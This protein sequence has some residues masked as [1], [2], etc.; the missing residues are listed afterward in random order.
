MKVSA[1]ADY[2]VRAAIEIAAS[3]HVPVKAERI[4]DRQAIPLTFLHKILHELRMAG[5]IRTSRGPEGGHEL[6]RPPSEISIADVL[7]AVEGPL[8]AVRNAAPESVQYVGSAAPLQNVWIAL[9]TNI[10]DVLESVSLVD[11]AN[12]ELPEHVIGLAGRPESWLTR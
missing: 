6:A 3:D 4:A 5:L 12:D 11:V 2:A 7:R 10:R 1:K 8:A 9:R